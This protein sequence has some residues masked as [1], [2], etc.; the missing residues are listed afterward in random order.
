MNNPLRQFWF[1]HYWW[2]TAVVLSGVIACVVSSRSDQA[3]GLCATLAGVGLTV[4]YFVQQQKLQE[5]QL[6]DK[7]FTQFNKRYAEL[8]DRLQAIL[9][10]RA[11]AE[12]TPEVRRWL[13]DYFNLC[14]EEYLFYSEG[15][16]HPRAWTA[17]CR[18]MLYYLEADPRILHYWQGQVSNDSHYGLTLDKIEAGAGRRM[19]S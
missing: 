1:R 18:G 8:N 14:A 12:I 13:D 5:I 9:A 19:N 15:R 3:L 6:F 2:L 17:W 16:I 10:D 4:I 11:A 7:L